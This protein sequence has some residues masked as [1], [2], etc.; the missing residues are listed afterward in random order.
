M[1]KRL[2]I[3]IDFNTVEKDYFYQI[4][5][6]VAKYCE[7]ARFSDVTNFHLTLKFIGGVEESNVDDLIHLIDKLD[8]NQLELRFDHIGF[9]AKKNRY[10]L[11]IGCLPN[12]KLTQLAN[13]INDEVASLGLCEKEQ[14]IYTPHLTLARQAKLLVPSVDLSRGIEVDKLVKI[15]NITLYESK[16]IEGELKYIPLYVRQ[17]K[18]ES[19][20]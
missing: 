5:M 14:P 17:L 3:G 12:Y 20:G 10:I 6:M 4:Q 16:N 13:K 9:F 11:Y 2:F 18:E 7:S 1:V 19:R 15:N 8:A